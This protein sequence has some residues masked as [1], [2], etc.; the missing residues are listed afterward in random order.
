MCSPLSE[1][2]LELLV[3]VFLVSKTFKEIL[4]KIR[5]IYLRKNMSK[6][7]NSDFGKF[8]RIKYNILNLNSFFSNF[9]LILFSS[10]LIKII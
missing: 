3:V 5:P 6:Y 7:K 1:E 4:N 8:F 10:I 9:K 2:L